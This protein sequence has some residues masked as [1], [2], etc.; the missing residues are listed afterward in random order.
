MNQEPEIVGERRLFT[1]GHVYVRSGLP[2]G[3]T[4]YWECYKLRR[5]ECRARATT[6]S[7]GGGNFTVTKESVHDHPPNREYVAAEK[8][9]MNVKRKAEEHPEEPPSRILRTELENVPSAV[10][11]QLPERENLKKSIRGTRRKNLPDNPTSLLEL[12]ELPVDFK[13]TTTGDQFLIYD[14]KND[15]DDELDGR[16]IVFATRRNLELLA[17]SSMWFLDGTFKVRLFLTNK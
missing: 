1:N 16:I 17:A 7:T 11:S 4:T 8:I 13:K 15:D 9:R 5:K 14:S 3:N 2:V 10:L 6:K 12:G